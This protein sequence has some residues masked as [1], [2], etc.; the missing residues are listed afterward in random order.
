MSLTFGS[1]M[2]PEVSTGSGLEDRLYQRVEVEGESERILLGRRGD[3]VLRGWLQSDLLKPETRDMDLT[4]E[5]I[6]VH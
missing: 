1:G 5:C 2:L 3:R 4:K 6:V